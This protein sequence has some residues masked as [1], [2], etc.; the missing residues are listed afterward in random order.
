MGLILQQS[1]HPDGALQCLTRATTLRPNWTEAH[2]NLGMLL[3]ALGRLEEAARCYRRVLSLE[4]RQIGAL[5]NLGNILF[6][7]G[8]TSAAIRQFRQVLRRQPNLAAVHYGILRVLGIE[9]LVAAD[10]AEYVAL[11]VK[12]GWIKIGGLTCGRPSSSA[13]IDSSTTASA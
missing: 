7:T 12:L 9:A 8:Q 2:Y 3:Q 10:K 11:A 6:A 5:N 13:W 1:G 4:P